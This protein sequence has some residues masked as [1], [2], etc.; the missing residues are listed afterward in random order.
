MKKCPF[1]AEEIQDEAIKCKHCNEFLDVQEK[2]YPTC[3]DCGGKLSEDGEF[4]SECGV[5][6]S[7]E[8]EIYK[9]LNKKNKFNKVQ[10]KKKIKW[11]KRWD[12]I[13]IIL[14]GSVIINSILTNFNNS[15]N[16]NN[17][18]SKKVEGS[19]DK[20]HDI[21]RIENVKLINDYENFYDKDL[22]SKESTKMANLMYGIANG[23]ERFAP[24]NKHIIEL[25]IKF[26]NHNDYDV[27][28]IKYSCIQY[29][30]SGSAINRNEGVKHIAIGSHGYVYRKLNLGFKHDDVWVIICEC[31]G[32][33]K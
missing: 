17:E 13:L 3:A 10:S 33:S 7:Q 2:F 5:M 8:N 30:E 21:K 24:L 18:T 28:D 15:T 29:A 20:K 4:C 1:C 26:E 32:F 19:S 11:F 6:Q 31:T 16:F 22:Y 27:R 14:I 23:S 25:Y 9:N 12:V